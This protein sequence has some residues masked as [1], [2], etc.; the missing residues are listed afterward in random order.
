MS[1]NLTV[2]DIQEQ[3]SR[4]LYHQLFRPQ[5]LEVDN[6][7]QTLLLKVRWCPEFERQ[8]DTD[9][10][11]GGVIASLVDITGCYALMLVAAGPMLTL[12][13][14]TDFLRLA[15]NTDLTAKAKVRRS[16]RTAGF[17]DVDIYDDG[18]KLVAVGR[19][20]YAIKP[21]QQNN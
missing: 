19:A 15:Q 7:Q 12:N 2:S 14:S 18:E 21:P 6:D 10:W 13:F 4:S 5:V 3:I 17:V 11:H 8:P 1:N 16:G 20:C 9:Q